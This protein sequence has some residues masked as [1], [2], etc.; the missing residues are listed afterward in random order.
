MPI[1]LDAAIVMESPAV[2][3][4]QQLAP[5]AVPGDLASPAFFVAPEGH[6]DSDGSASSP[7]ATIGRAQLAMEQGSTRTTY[8]RSGTYRLARPIFLDKANS[9]MVFSAYPGQA[10]VLDGGAS[11]LATL[12]Q[13]DGV[14]N[15]TLT[16]L[17][18]ANGTSGAPAVS[19]TNSTGVQILGNRFVD[20]GTAILL[21]GSSG[22]TVSGNLIENSAQ[23]AIEAKDGS[24]GNSF[25]G[26]IIDRTGA[27][28]E[29]GGGFFLHGASD[30]AITHNLVE[31]TAGVGIAIENWDDTT[32]N[33]GNTI[34]YNVV[35]NTSTASV[36]SGAIYVL[37][38]S[39]VDT[40]T[41]I[42]GNFIDGT[43]AGGDAHTIG[44]Y[45]DDST[46]DVLVT[47]NIIRRIGSHGAQVHGGDDN[48]I[49]NN[50]FDLGS[51]SATAVLFQSAP[52]DTH[53]TNTMLN[54]RVVGNIILS[55]SKTPEWYSHLEG[56]NP[57]IS[58]N[59]YYGEASAAIPSVPAVLDRSPHYGDPGFI[60]VP[61]G[62]YR[63]APGSAAAAIGFRQIDQTQMGPRPTVGFWSATR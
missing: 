4:A 46:S 20:N 31:N 23:S 10:P 25:D 47:S 40:R 11:G 5:G 52:A 19:L 32:I 55:S 29:Q 21:T 33:V 2:V 61:A 43:G 28:A 26:N 45:L 63:L 6:D 41:V 59:L 38:R 57:I 16:G 50:I 18:F 35:R 17:T 58:C 56:G 54:N 53:P 14:S 37:G 60:D 62:D 3:L 12:V 15:V 7:F 34:A 9:G 36:D 27:I 30:N 44:I 48:T 22:N 13:L 51:S 8:L 42:S 24:N 49:T 1:F 39:H